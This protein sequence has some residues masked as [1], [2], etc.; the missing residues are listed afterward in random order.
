MR[1]FGLVLG[2]VLICHESAFAQQNQQQPVQPLLGQPEANPRLDA[3]LAQWEA[4]MTG[5]KSLK[6]Q[7]ARETESKAFR[8]KEVM[9]GNAYYQA[10]NLAR[11]ELK[12]PANPNKFECIVCS[13][14]FT[15]QYVPEA[16]QIRVYD[17]GPAKKGQLSEDNFLSFLIGMKAADA[18]SRYIL[19]LVKEDANYIYIEVKPRD[20]RDMADFSLAQLALTQKTFLPRM[21]IYTAGNGDVATW[22]I[23]SLEVD[24]GLGIAE[25]FEKA[26]R[27][28]AGIRNEAD[29]SRAQARSEC[30]SAAAY[31]AATGPLNPTR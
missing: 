7:I 27:E 20:P 29:C 22:N 14:Q 5:I 13:G 23:P 31:H 18:K 19:K 10:P 11:L 4:K 16:K 3:L 26:T 17:L 12:L 30:R 8:V 1:Y 15:Y 24:T 25:I 28:A 21:L 2:L 6:A 9:V